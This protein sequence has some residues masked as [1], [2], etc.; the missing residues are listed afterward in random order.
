MTVAMYAVKFQRYW[1][2]LRSTNTMFSKVRVLVI[3]PSGFCYGLQHISIDLFAHAQSRLETHFLITRWSNGDFEK[4]ISKHGFSYTFSWMGMFSRKFDLRN[5]RMSLLSLVKL[6]QLYIDFWRVCWRFKPAVIFFANH[7]ELILL[8]PMLWFTRRKVVCH[9]HDPS[10]PVRFQQWTFSFYSKRVD[11]FI[12][13]SNDVKNRLLKLG[14]VS[15]KTTVVRNGVCI[16]N[17]T[18]ET[19]ERFFQNQF[20]WLEEVFIVGLTGQ[21]TATKGHEDLLEAFYLAYQHN[22]KL[23]LVIGGKPLYPFYD[24]L[25]NS[26]REKGLT[27]VV[28]FS[29]WLPESSLFYQSIDLFVLASR[30]DEGYGLVVAEAMAHAK[31]V[32]ITASGGAMEIVEDGVSGFIVPKRSIKDLADKIVKLSQ[33]PKR[34]RQLSQAAR[35]RVQ[36]KFSMAAA[37]HNFAEVI[38]STLNR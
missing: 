35:V 5:L 6:P 1:K 38:A 33:E 37:A 30:H 14:E 2:S 34:Y 24:Q 32:V 22:P 3:I 29:G 15:A 10:P 20:H 31:P 28:A 8:T 17:V 23:R 26:V 19:R 7:H 21:M 4:M 11:L 9:M 16:P 27:K 36:E 25:Q 18:L 13:I 12:T